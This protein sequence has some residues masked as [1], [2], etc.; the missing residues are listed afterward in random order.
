M[1]HSFITNI[2]P[3][4]VC[5]S[6]MGF[7]SAQMLLQ[8]IVDVYIILLITVLSRSTLGPWPITCNYLYTAM[9]SSWIMTCWQFT[10][11]STA[12]AEW[13]FVVIL[14]P[15]NCSACEINS[16]FCSVIPIKWRICF[17]LP[18]WDVTPQNC[19]IYS[20]WSR[21]LATIM[22]ASVAK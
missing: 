10:E 19:T 2:L 1:L 16:I 6:D 7:F 12:W 5:F 13:A 3:P 11:R 14:I 4:F 20:V 9:T 8:S 15:D 22:V 21:Y 18:S 17:I